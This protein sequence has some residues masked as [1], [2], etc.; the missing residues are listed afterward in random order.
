MDRLSNAYH[1]LDVKFHSFCIGHS[2]CKDPMAQLAKAAFENTQH[3]R[4]IV[5]PSNVHRK[6]IV[7]IGEFVLKRTRTE[8]P[9]DTHL[10]RVSKAAKIRRYLQARG[11]DQHFVVPKKFILL[12]EMG[13]WVV[14]VQKI[15]HG[16]KTTQLNHAQ[17]VGLAELI[18]LGLL[19]PFNAQNRVLAD[20][21]D[22]VAILDTAPLGR[23][24]KL[25][26]KQYRIGHFLFNRTMVLPRQLC[27]TA[28]LKNLCSEVEK[29]KIEEIEIQ[30]YRKGMAYSVGRVAIGCL[31]L[32]ILPSITSAAASL[33]V[34]PLISST[35]YAGVIGLS[36]IKILV[37]LVQAF[38]IHHV[39]K[40]SMQREQGLTAL[41]T[42]FQGEYLSAK[43]KE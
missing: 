6:H 23:Q 20:L 38:S 17:A 35:V 22:R 31:G 27:A 13:E 11:L 30:E 34:N 24:I 19:S 14:I 33:P 5:S 39:Y 25:A 29:E 21:K 32:Y 4:E 18:F 37:S 16:V 41:E 26:I 28:H 36:S 9:T 2:L 1:D 42:Y 10:H 40:T 3:H 8:K 7:D 12:T 15:P 43:E